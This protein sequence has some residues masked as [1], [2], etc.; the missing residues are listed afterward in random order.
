MSSE[1]RSLRVCAAI[2][3]G[4]FIVERKEDQLIFIG[5]KRRLAKRERQEKLTYL[6]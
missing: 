3:G 4:L 2:F 6:S 1:D 5:G